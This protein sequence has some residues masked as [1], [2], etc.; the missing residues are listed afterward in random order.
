MNLA[1]KVQYETSSFVWTQ[2][3]RIEE[4]PGEGTRRESRQAAALFLP[5]DVNR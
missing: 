2:D 4:F 5:E 1:T 3:V